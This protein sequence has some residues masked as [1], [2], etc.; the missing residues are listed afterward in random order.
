M[1]GI[2]KPGK[3]EETQKKIEELRNK[4]LTFSDKLRSKFSNY[5]VAVGL[6]P[7]S[8][9]SYLDREIKKINLIV[10]VNDNDRR[11]LSRIELKEKVSKIVD[12]LASE[13]DKSLE[14]ETILL[15]ELWYNCLYGNYKVLDVLQTVAPV[16]D[17]GVLSG[18]KSA[19]IHKTMINEKFSKFIKSYVLIGDLAN[20]TPSMANNKYNVDI[21]VVIDDSGVKDMS[22]EELKE[23]LRVI[24]ESKALESQELTGD[25][26]LLNT[27]IFFLTEL[28]EKLKGGD[29]DTL[30]MLRKGVPIIDNGIFLSW[31]QLLEKGKFQPDLD[32]LR[33]II[34]SKQNS[35][36]V[37]KKETYVGLINKLYNELIDLS[38]SVL[39]HH[40]IFCEDSEVIQKLSETLIKENKVNKNYLQTLSKLHEYKRNIIEGKDI[41]FNSRVMEELIGESQDFVNKLSRVY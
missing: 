26:C 14:P 41:K 2:K 16:Y 22:L 28:W 36:D 31:K 30:N 32:S 9:I 15:S 38:Q 34:K 8:N 12:Q 19:Q 13:V 21:G 20:G 5:I 33:E 17:N 25:K 40:N 3:I 7:S 35:F 4:L 1:V 27:Q 23:K 37:I 18:I 10:I 29:P 11:K 39:M 6:L 24:S